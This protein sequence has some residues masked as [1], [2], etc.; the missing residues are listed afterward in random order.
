MDV[1]SIETRASW[2]VASVAVAVLAVSFGA[3]FII[4]VAMKPIAADMGG[5]R[6]IPALA[7]SLAWFSAALGATVMSPLAERIGVRLTA[8]FGAC[9][10]AIGLMLSS[11]G[12]TWQ[13]YV[14]HGLFI[15]LLGNA[16]INAPL[17]VYITRWFDKNRG[18]ALALIT[19]GQYLAGA[20]WPM[21]LER[22]IA[23][24]GWQQTMF[25]YAAV[26]V[27]VVV[28]L[29]GI[30]F[31]PPPVIPQPAAGSAPVGPQVGAPVLGMRPGV[32]FGLMASANFLCCVPMA[33]PS[34]HMVAFC[35][36]LGMAASAG[37]AMLSLLLV[38]AMFSRQAW[39][40]LSDRI[41]G[42]LTL[43]LS[44]AAQAAAIAGFAMTQDEAGL[45][46]VAA[47]FGLGFSGLIPA[48]VL[49]VRE[50]FPSSEASWRVPVLLLS[51]G[52]G[53]AFGGW[54]A[55]HIYDQ[56]GYY[57]PAFA[58]GLVFNLI[59]FVIIAFLVWRW[60]GTARSARGAVPG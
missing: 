13:L 33:M 3:V 22:T 30:F 8:M 56:A 16:G 39:G 14:G 54:F 40:W 52:T 2:V 1:T 37:A 4:V 27:L 55:G 53:M 59:N 46:F 50:L 6:S 24:W 21:V 18:T 10:V 60:W 44:S 51:G 5:Q 29:A 41:G 45:Y 49:V 26:V 15:G 11:M 36:D 42:L 57:A 48:Y 9:M 20:F 47:A 35:G 17:Y 23:A 12:E 38:C 28:P 43:L 7:H 34:A 19:S 58:T 32:V 25:V 31:K